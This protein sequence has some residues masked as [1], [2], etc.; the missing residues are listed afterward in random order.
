MEKPN[1]V[2]NLARSI[3]LEDEALHFKSDIQEENTT[4]FSRIIEVCQSLGLF[5]HMPGNL[6]I[7]ISDPSGL[8]E[9]L[10]PIPWPSEFKNKGRCGK[11]ESHLR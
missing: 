4:P 5:E 11:K 7:S 10:A 9:E 2:S 8:I 1:N 6:T 3:K